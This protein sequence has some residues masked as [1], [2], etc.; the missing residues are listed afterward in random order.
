MYRLKN[1]AVLIGLFG[2]GLLGPIFNTAASWM[3]ADVAL[4]IL[5]LSGL[6]L[7]WPISM[8][9]VTV[10]EPVISGTPWSLTVRNGYWP[11]VML[12][13]AETVSWQG[14][15]WHRQQIPVTQPLQ[16][17]VYQTLPFEWRVQVPGLFEKRALLRLQQPMV[18]LPKANLTQ[19]QILKDRLTTEWA[20]IGQNDFQIRDFHPYQLGDDV[21]LIDWH[22]TAKHGDVIV[23]EFEQ[24][25]PQAP[26]FAFINQA[27]EAY[28][29]RL[30][31]FAGLIEQGA[32][33]WVIG[34]QITVTPTLT[35]LALLEPD[36]QIAALPTQSGLVVLAPGDWVAPDDAQ[37]RIVRLSHQQWQVTGG[38]Q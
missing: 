7:I 24:A 4:L 31:L 13:N 9:T 11:A 17:G 27:D 2:L 25:Q 28:E 37:I 16:R 15:V 21:D 33:A 14:S 8:L 5:G 34:S 30:S 35:D 29:A 18:V 38:R 6:S 1:I 22:Q 23:R 19:A 26:V 32:D 20:T 36:T 10:D 3:M 12:I